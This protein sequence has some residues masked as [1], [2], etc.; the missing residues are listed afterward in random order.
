MKRLCEK[1][2][3]PFKVGGNRQRVC[4]ACKARCQECG[5]VLNAGTR[6]VVCS[7]CLRLDDRS[8][9]RAALRRIEARQRRELLLAPR[10]TWRLHSLAATAEHDAP[11]TD[12]LHRESALTGGCAARRHATSGGGANE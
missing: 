12:A 5:K 9:E 7:D 6:G 3:Q 11:S 10:P 2:D 4:P 1:C 8:H